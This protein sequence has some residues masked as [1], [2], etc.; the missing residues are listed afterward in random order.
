MFENYNIFIEKFITK[1]L[2]VHQSFINPIIALTETYKKY[3]ILPFNETTL[4]NQ[5]KIIFEILTKYINNNYQKI[6]SIPSIENIT[7]YF[8]DINL[9]QF[10]IDMFNVSTCFYFEEY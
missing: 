10:T 3:D 1:I 5:Y 6:I 2:D 9:T 8:K 4:N 7:N